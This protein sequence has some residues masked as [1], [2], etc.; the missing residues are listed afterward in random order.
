MELFALIYLGIGLVHANNK[1]NNSNPAL[2]PTWASDQSLPFS[3]R[4]AGFLFIAIIWPISMF[5]R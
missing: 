2:R 3:F 1:V 4:T 5:V